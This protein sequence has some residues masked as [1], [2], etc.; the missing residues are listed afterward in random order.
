ME[1]PTKKFVFAKNKFDLPIIVFV[2]GIATTYSLF[3]LNEV[4]KSID[5][6]EIKVI[7]DF[8]IRCFLMPKPI[9]LLSKDR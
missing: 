9:V 6:Q 1:K 7:Y 2:G 5:R 8:K 3:S 4:H